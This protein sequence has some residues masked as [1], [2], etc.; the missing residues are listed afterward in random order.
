M[1]PDR[2]LPRSTRRLLATMR[3]QY[4]RSIRDPESHRILRY[5]LATNPEALPASVFLSMRDRIRYH[6]EDP[7]VVATLPVLYGDPCKGGGVGDCNDFAVS[8]AALGKIGR[9]QVRWALG[10]DAEGFPAHVWT[11]MRRDQGAWIDVDPTPG[12]PAPGGG[13]PVDVPGARIVGW[14]PIDVE[15]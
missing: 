9:Y 11:Q 1:N 3:R 13:S 6:H 7:H 5:I 10:L 15:R 14:V 4:R 8:T 12:A 2:H